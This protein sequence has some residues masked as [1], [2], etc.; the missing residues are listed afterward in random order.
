MKE[1]LRTVLQCLPSR[2]W[3]AQNKMPVAPAVHHTRESVARVLSKHLGE[4][5]SDEPK[6][7]AMVGRRVLREKFRRAD[8]GIDLGVTRR[9]PASAKPKNV[10]PGCCQS[11]R[12][13]SPVGHSSPLPC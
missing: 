7:L 9:R 3:P 2:E 13:L 8:L 5:L 4:Q 1:I 10:V 11:N 6:A 12:H